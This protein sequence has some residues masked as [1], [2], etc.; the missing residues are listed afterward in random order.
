MSADAA[1]NALLRAALDG[2]HHERFANLP[3]VLIERARRSRTGRRLLLRYLM[4]QTPQLFSGAV[5]F[6]ADLLDRHPWAVWSGEHL[7]G[8]AADLGALALSPALRACVDRACVLRLRR[9][10]SAA[11]FAF[12]LSFDAWPAQVPEAIEKQARQALAKVIE[13][14]AAIAQLVARRGRIELTAYAERF[15]PA[16]AERV[17]LAFPARR[18]NGFQGKAWLPARAVARYLAAHERADSS[19]SQAEA[20]AA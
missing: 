18:R 1:W 8:A 13:N 15:L 2:A 14:P 6:D 9:A 11:R 5:D 7:R 12:A 10:I 3:P 17:R 19:P 20:A 4:P 16:M